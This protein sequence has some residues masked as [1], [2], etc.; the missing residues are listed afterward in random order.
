MPA[1]KC[2]L[3]HFYPKKAIN[4]ADLP[5]V[6]T[7]TTALALTAELFDQIVNSLKSDIGRRTNEK[8]TKPRVGVRGR[9]QILPINADGTVAQKFDVW[10]RD[11]SASGIGILHNSPLSTG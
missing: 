5:L 10:V 6:E 11:V 3:P 9:V 4:F 2:R 7:A 1:P 8:R